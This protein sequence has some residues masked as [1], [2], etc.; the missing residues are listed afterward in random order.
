MDADSKCY[1]NSYTLFFTDPQNVTAGHG[2][3]WT[4]IGHGPASFFDEEVG[5]GLVLNHIYLTLAEVHYGR[6]LAAACGPGFC[7]GFDARKSM[8]TLPTP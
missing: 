4:I 7:I 6:R 8:W 2:L 5:L 1:T 3:S